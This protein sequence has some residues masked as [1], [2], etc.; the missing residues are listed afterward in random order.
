MLTFLDS[1]SM[2]HPFFSVHP[3]AFS[4]RGGR[5][6][7]P[8][9][10]VFAFQQSY[11]LGYR[12]FETDLHLTKDGVVVLLHDDYLDRTTD[13]TGDVWEYTFEELESF[14]AA[15]RFGADREW[16]YRGQGIT[17]PTLEEIVTTFPDIRL[18][19]EL[20][21]SGLEGPLVAL[22]ERLDLWDRVII[23]GFDDRWSR[24]VRKASGGRVL[25]SS[26]VWETRAFWLASRA[27]V[28]LR[29]PAAALQVPVRHGNLTIVDDKFVGAAHRADKQVHVWTVNE[30]DEMHRLLDLG[31]DGLMSDRPDVLKAVHEERGVAL[32]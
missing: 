15:F 21:Q 4:H 20:K 30:A 28:G 7:W 11:D 1:F 14:D 22:L 16:P 31:V 17:I 23:G 2:T 3:T 25:T 13:G 29:L 6:L 27:G 32:A 24:A 9:N 19:L 5:L 10:T 26:G 18:T 12:Y 8:E